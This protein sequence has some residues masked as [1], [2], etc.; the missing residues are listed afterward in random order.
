MADRLNFANSIVEHLPFLKRVVYRLTHGDQM[1]D[2]IVQQTMLK[3]LIHAEQFRF[4]S[5]LKA[6]LRSIAINEVHQVYRSI[7]GHALYRC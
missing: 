4:E 6:W 5:T 2:D 7:G 3:A 1:T